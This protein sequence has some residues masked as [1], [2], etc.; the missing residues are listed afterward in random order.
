MKSFLVKDIDSFSLQN[1][2]DG[3]CL[4]SRREKEAYGI[5]IQGFNLFI[6]EYSGSSTRASIH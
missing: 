4:I 5:S 2:N 3:L 6:P 1:Q